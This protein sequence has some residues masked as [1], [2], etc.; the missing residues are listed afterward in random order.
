MSIP[1]TA[2]EPVT[3]HPEE[4]LAPNPAEPLSPNPPEVV[5]GPDVL[6]PR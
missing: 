3:P 6:P 4:P 2:P 1:D 5:P